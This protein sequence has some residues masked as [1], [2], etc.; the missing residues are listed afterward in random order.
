M[1]IMMW[2]YT[3]Y[4]TFA[5]NAYDEI[6]RTFRCIVLEKSVVRL[7]V[8]PSSV[9]NCRRITIRNLDNG[10]AKS[11][12]ES[13]TINWRWHLDKENVLLIC[14]TCP[15]SRLTCNEILSIY[16]EMLRYIEQTIPC[17]VVATFVVRCVVAPS[18]VAAMKRL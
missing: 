11:T 10:E 9:A 5:V 7:V 14:G 4:V 3:K 1:K 12:A 8:T 2:F 16:R 17:V 13:C 6:H 15:A 18:V